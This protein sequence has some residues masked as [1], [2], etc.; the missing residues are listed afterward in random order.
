MHALG[1]RA[2]ASPKSCPIQMMTRPPELRSGDESLDPGP[3]FWQ[4]RPM[5]WKLECGRYRLFIIEDGFYWRD[6]TGYHP[7][8]NDNDWRF[9]ARDEQGRVRM[10]FGCYVIT[11]GDHTVMVD[12][13]IGEPTASTPAG[14]TTGRM[15]QALEGLGIPPESVTRVVYTHMH[16]DHIAGSRRKGRAVLPAARHIFHE[17]EWEH[18]SGEDSERAEA[19]RRV[20]QPFID[21]G[22]VDPI[23]GDR[24]VLPGVTAVEAFGHTPGHLMV[25]IISE[26]TRTILGGDVSNHPFQVEH[27]HWSLP[28]D[29]DPEMAG[30]TRDR[31]FEEVRGAGASFVAGHYPMPGIGKI[32]IDDQMRV[33]LPG[34]ASQVD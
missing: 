23:D 26:G 4:Y 10:N 5:I 24:E 30:N 19:A 14:M 32:V 21:E 33:F 9:H 22:M 2:L 8:A 29:V 15:P 16:Y 28:V 27:P 17:K 7:E 6:P 18:W 31:V 12:A 1:G 20:V 13:G 11:D 34:T 3:S 25:S